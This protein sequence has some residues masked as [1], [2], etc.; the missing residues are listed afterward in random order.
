MTTEV[1]NTVVLLCGLPGVGK[2]TVASVLAEK[3]QAKLIDNHYIN[4]VLFHLLEPDGASSLPESVWVETRKV[5]EAVLSIVAHHAPREHNYI[6][7]N[8][9]VE[10]AAR[11]MVSYYNLQHMVG[12]RGARFIPVLLRCSAETHLQRIT[13]DDRKAR[14][15]QT[16][17]KSLQERLNN[18]MKA[19]RPDHPALLE[20]N[21]TTASPEDSADAI[22]AH[23][24]KLMEGEHDK[25]PL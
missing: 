20:L 2:Y 15:K 24:H 23:I 14:H 22:I 8:A 11:D 17:A 1:R 19:F 5:R 25:L 3:L 4:N 9:L 18:G 13:G 7:T 6:F 10:G 12:L 21:V 16:S